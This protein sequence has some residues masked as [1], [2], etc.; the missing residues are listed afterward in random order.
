METTTM[1]DLQ[2]PTSS[3]PAPS[4]LPARDDAS[5]T[6]ALAHLA[7]MSG[8]GI[9]YGTMDYVALNPLAILSLLI[10]MAGLLSLLVS[11]FLFLPVIAIA[12]GL[13]AFRQIRRSNGTQGGYG[14]ATAGIVVALLVGGLVGA[15]EANDW[16]IVRTESREAADLLSRFGAEVAAGHYENAYD[17]FT[18]QEFRSRVDRR[19]FR[20]MF[21]ELQH[22]PGYGQLQ[23]IEWN[24]EKMLIENLPN[25]EIRVMCL[26]MFQYRDAKEPGREYFR[27]NYVEG[28]WKISGIPR[29]FPE[30]KPGRGSGPRQ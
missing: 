22:I 4:E 8:T 19:A 27:L 23:G 26:T 11:L 3:S 16:M 9:A 21:E 5:G 25:G 15:R 30:K 2:P 6:E 17:G 20:N 18:T 24:G 29:L 1:P 28:S 12:C 10:A 7:R 13:L 14:F